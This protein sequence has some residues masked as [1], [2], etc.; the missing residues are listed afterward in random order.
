M[1]SAQQGS[2]SVHA[3][4][5]NDHGMKR[6]RIESDGAAE[7]PNKRS[8]TVDKRG[9]MGS[10][11]IFSWK[12][13]NELEKNAKDCCI[14]RA[15]NHVEDCYGF[16]ERVRTGE[17][18]G[19]VFKDFEYHGKVEREVWYEDPRGHGPN[20]F[21]IM[22]IHYDEEFD[23]QKYKAKQPQEAKTITCVNLRHHKTE[24]SKSKKKTGF[25]ES[26]FQNT[27]L[28]DEGKILWENKTGWKGSKTDAHNTYGESFQDMDI[29]RTDDLT[30]FSKN[31]KKMPLYL[32][33]TSD[34]GGFSPLSPSQKEDAFPWQDFLGKLNRGIHDGLKKSYPIYVEMGAESADSIGV[35][36][37]AFGNNNY[38]LTD[39]WND[40]KLKNA[41]PDARAVADA[42]RMIGAHTKVAE[43]V[44]D[45]VIMGEILEEWAE[46]RL[47]SD[48]RVVFIFWAG[49]AFQ[50]I[51]DTSTHLVP[52]GDKWKATKLQPGRQTF[53]VQEV[54]DIVRKHSQKS[55][56]IVCLDSCRTEMTDSKWQNMQ[57][58][59]G[60]ADTQSHLDVEIWFSTAHGAT[61]S[62]GVADHSD[63]TGSI[64]KV[65]LR[66]LEN[67]TFDEIWNDISTEMKKRCPDQVLSRYSNGSSEHKTLLPQTV[68]P[69]NEVNQVVIYPCICKQHTHIHIHTYIHNFQN[70]H[71]CIGN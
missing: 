9:M 11:L 62:D 60:G 51:G 48:V 68:A 16:L 66:D 21:V 39:L 1:S 36:M 65:L 23:T 64:L 27:Y 70:D 19:V 3:E 42:F 63:F 31:Q 49:H 10:L 50:I 26:I 53:S 56:V 28:E 34:R 8:L 67:K 12:K 6:H 61:S 58:S 24:P 5:Q 46:A 22:H 18:K 69:V 52:T 55:R 71:T 37:L 44:K 29:D 57:H 13:R 33:A 2:G 35:E 32:P 7:K 20:Q 41:I 43:D 59:K 4:S 25:Y 40:G 15:F 17:A 54:I 38:S 30:Y 47:A 45:P 14:A